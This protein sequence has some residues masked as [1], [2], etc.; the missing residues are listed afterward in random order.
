METI[1]GLPAHPLFVHAPV[2]LMPLTLIAMMV[3]A[4][5]PQLR[6]RSGL[7]LAAAALVVLLSTQLSIM[8]GD[9]F[10]EALD[11]AVN[12]DD[13]ADLAQ[14]TRNFLVVFV[15]AATG[16]A[17]LDRKNSEGAPRWYG[18]TSTG[19]VA[20]AAVSSLLATVWMVRTGDEGARLVWDNLLTT[21]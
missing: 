1:N 12:V 11:G 2:V 20:V 18:P 6:R 7:A 21:S 5:R 8:S 19:L 9:A 10:D 17:V 15:L 13:H 14:T 3:L 16:F 4:A